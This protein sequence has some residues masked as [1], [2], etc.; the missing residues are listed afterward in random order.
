MVGWA[1]VWSGYREVSFYSAEYIEDP[2]LTTTADAREQEALQAYFRAERQVRDRA[3]PV[4]LPLAVGNM[5]L[6]G[7][8]VLAASRAFGGRPGARSLALQAL[9]ANGMLAV[10]DYALSRHMRGELVPAMA[11]VTRA[12]VK[13][14]NPIP[15][16]DLTASL[17]S[18]VW[19]GF[20]LQLLLVLALYVASWLVLS[21]DAA[22]AY[23]IDASPDDEP[24]GE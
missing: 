10:A 22:R 2:P 3:R 17:T 11:Q 20:R 24:E 1:G 8:L 21:T 7:L 13:P 19:M 6:S 16:A 4:R 12:M 5:L 15:E 14:T 18:A 9:G 23:L